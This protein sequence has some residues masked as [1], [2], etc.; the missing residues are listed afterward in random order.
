MKKCI[1][2]GSKDF[3][4]KSSRFCSQKCIHLYGTY[5]MNKKIKCEICNKEISKAN[6]KKHLKTHEIKQYHYF[7]EY[8]N[9]E[10][11]E[12]YGSGRFCSSKCARGFSTKAKRKEINRIIKQKKFLKRKLQL[13]KI[14]KTYK[15]KKIHIINQQEYEKECLG[16]KKIFI[17]FNLN[18]KYCSKSCASHFSQLGKKHKPI[19]DTSKMG[20]LRPG[21]GK[22]KQIP[23][24]NW[25]G[26]K[27]YLNK[28]EIKVAKILDEKKLNWNRNRKG[29]LYLTQDGK[30]RK[31]YPDF[32]INENE[33][34]EYKGWVTSEMEWKMKDAKE[35][36]NL[37]L[38]IIVGED[39]R[40]KDF[41]ISLQEYLI[42]K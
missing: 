16:C 29:F 26:Y 3:K 5:K 28:E 41:G 8:C 19:K 23:Y 2:C 18:K 14:E 37:N 24:I 33:Y 38:T 31:Y 20:G 17:T 12:K 21:G 22:S 15:I 13:Q 11:F 25:L 36:N 4:I 35:K 7:C 40:Y 34:I 32:V 39:K 6:Y 42:N 1:I 10:V 27:M 30:H 9:K